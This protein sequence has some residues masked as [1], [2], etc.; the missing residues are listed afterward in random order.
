M[1]KLT[2]GNIQ[3]T[4][5]LFAIPLVLSGLLTQAYN[6][7]DTII[8]GKY[9]GEAGLAAIGAT[10]LF[11]TFISSLFTGYLVGFSIYLSKLFGA[12]EFAKIRRGVYI[13]TVIC[14]IAAVSISV[15]VIVF[16]EP[17]FDLLN[18]EKEIR[19][20]T[21]KY[22]SIYMS[23]FFLLQLSANGTYTLGA[24]GDSVFPFIMSLVSAVINIVGNILSVAVFGL[25][26][27]GLALSTVISAG[28]VGICFAVR[29][30]RSIG[31]LIVDKKKLPRS[32]IEIKEGLPY[33]LPT[34]LQ[35]ASI[36]VAGFVLS[37]LINVTGSAAIASYVVTSQILTI[38]NH[39]YQISLRTVSTY[40]SQCLGTDNTVS[41]KRKM[42]SR[43]VRVGYL[44]ATLFVLVVL[45]PCII[46]PEFVSSLFFSGNDDAE[47]M[48]LAVTF[49]RVFLPFVLINIINSLFH[50]FFRGVKAMKLLIFATVFGSAIR[51]AASVPLTKT[52]GINGFY[53][54]MII[55][56]IIEAVVIFGIYK[57]K[58][59]MPDELKLPKKS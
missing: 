9:L 19:D 7:V 44:Q 30:S 45:I 26:V 1:K 57:S 20:D 24:L 11:I 46:F 36:Y 43:G 48:K 39:I 34:I 54:G 21:F 59:W 47:S 38:H 40:S 53:V 18:I 14:T 58:I 41:E 25:G 6:T 56:W 31:L 12:G 51:I 5:F 10:S 2:D 49:I 50:A 37:P 33:S 29:F 27:A 8:A 17:L 13:N 35:Q 52:Y 15:M 4:F 42:L 23:G 22:F 55:A 3:K 28:V 16:H 32:F